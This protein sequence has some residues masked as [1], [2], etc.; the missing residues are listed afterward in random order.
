MMSNVT[1][2]V[3]G[4]K[5][6]SDTPEWVLGV[7]EKCLWSVSHNRVVDLIV[8]VIESATPEPQGMSE[9]KL[10]LE[11]RLRRVAEMVREQIDV[12]RSARESFFAA[13]KQFDGLFDD[14]T[15][16]IVN[17]LLREIKGGGGARWGISPYLGTETYEWK[18]E[19]GAAMKR[20]FEKSRR[21]S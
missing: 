12:S 21:A 3:C 16:H 15:C 20:L 19:A 1:C 2:A 6:H 5:L 13:V 4:E 11:K 14:A 10:A 17:R 18:L 9:L 7:H 8:G